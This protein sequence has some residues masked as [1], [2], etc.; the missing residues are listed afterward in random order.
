MVTA[1]TVLMAMTV[2]LVLAM[3]FVALLLAIDAGLLA[4]QDQLFGQAG[5]IP[6]ALRAVRL[7]EDDAPPDDR[8]L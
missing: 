5:G 6:D 7:R 1:M 2:L 4:R 3:S 8:W